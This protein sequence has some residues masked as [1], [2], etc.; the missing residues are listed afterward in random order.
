VQEPGQELVQVPRPG[1]ELR[2]SPE[3]RE[4]PQFVPPKPREPL[5]YWHQRLE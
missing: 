5:P 4:R 3:P 2:A 1:Q